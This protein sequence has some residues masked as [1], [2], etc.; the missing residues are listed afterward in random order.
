M[1]WQT[2]HHRGA[3]LRSVIATADLRQDGLLPMDVDGVAETFRDELDLLGALQLRW[4]TRL[5]G[6]IEH[7]LTAE[8]MDLERRVALAWKATADDLPG[9]RRILD[10]YREHPVD[11]AMARAM[12][13]A[14]A[15]EHCFLAVM[16]GRAGVG[17]Q[18][19]AR[20][21]ARIEEEGR[22]LRETAAP[23]AAAEPA[24]KRAGL[25]DRLRAVVAA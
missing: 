1:T 10:H 3:I 6:N 5:G 12:A 21:G 13:K 11:D 25:L 15:K 4:H 23:V 17:D 16:A 14:T 2:Y 8:P 19:A 24:P 20:V 18:R 7:L 9:V 22:R